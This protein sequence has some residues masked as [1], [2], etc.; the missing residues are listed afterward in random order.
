MY[1]FFENRQSDAQ[2]NILPIKNVADYEATLERIDKLMDAKRD[3]LEG[4]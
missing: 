4:D 2:M 1:R 3:T